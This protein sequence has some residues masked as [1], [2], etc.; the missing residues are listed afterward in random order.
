MMTET[1]E[2]LLQMDYTSWCS[3]VRHILSR[4]LAL[5]TPT[6]PRQVPTANTSAPAF[7]LLRCPTC[8]LLWQIK[9]GGDE[10][11]IQKKGTSDVVLF[12]QSFARFEESVSA[13][14]TLDS[15][16]FVQLDLVMKLRTHPSTTMREL[17]DLQEAADQLKASREALMTKLKSAGSEELLRIVR[18]DVSSKC[19]KLALVYVHA[20]LTKAA[21]ARQR[22]HHRASRW[23]YNFNVYVNAK[24]PESPP[25]EPPRRLEPPAATA[26]SSRLPMALSWESEKFIDAIKFKNPAM[27]TDRASELAGK[28]QRHLIAATLSL[29]TNQKSRAVQQ[30]VADLR[31]KEDFQIDFLTQAG[32]ITA[33]L[34]PFLPQMP[35]AAVVA[36]RTK[37][38]TFPP[39][40]LHIK[41]FDKADAP[42]EVR[43][44]EVFIEQ[45][46]EQPGRGG[47]ANG[48]QAPYEPVTRAKSQR[49][50]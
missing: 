35:R 41:Y 37:R 5:G 30:I 49:I 48:R 39:N 24:T 26:T 34:A 7:P 43:D 21:H 1:E 20:K 31:D 47:P 27:T 44:A 9:G 12:P 25:S 40:L 32:T 11:F 6:V 42:G 15:V 13:L 33:Y 50:S 22:A 23:R 36:R 45:L 2:A 29:T 18:T 8:P 16:T 19:H 14:H 38:V 46:S 28:I 17:D 4:L 3:E 10:V